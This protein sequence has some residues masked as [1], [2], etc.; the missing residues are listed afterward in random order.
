[1]TAVTTSP[2]E[3]PTLRRS[4][5]PRGL[6]WTM[7]C[8]HR[9]ALLFWTL[10]VAVAA[11]AL[12]WAW[13]PGTSG[14]WTEYRTM[15]CAFPGQNTSCDY[16]GD[17]YLAFDLAT[18]LGG[19]I[20]TVVPFLVAVWAG[21]AL[22]A[23]ELETG[24]AELA[25]TQSVSPARWLVAKLAVPAVLIASGTVLLTLLHRLM[26]PSDRELLRWLG[27]HWYDEVAFR[28]N[29]PVAVAHALLGLA[30][31]VLVGLIV[32]RSLPALGISL[33]SLL[34]LH[35]VLAMARPY[36][37]PSVT[38]TNKEEFSV[39]SG[40]PV[41]AGGITSTGAHVPNPCAGEGPGCLPQHRIVGFY[42]DYH[43]SSHFWPL[44]IMETGVVLALAALAVLASF[45]LL[46]RH[47]GDAA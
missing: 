42:V 38:L 17:A 23:R 22:I 32:R 2:A 15:R 20:I 29:G 11:G 4:L 34:A 35:F 10:L 24:T 47:T 18:S 5:R 40:M 31:G 28:G 41:S 45:R 25:W 26:W 30:V 36:L 14:V 27:W 3:A 8:L 33:V 12:L 7:L 1:M 37:W 39:F 13:G 19:L 16:R 46:N 21:G 6:V 43:P 44:Q 9:A